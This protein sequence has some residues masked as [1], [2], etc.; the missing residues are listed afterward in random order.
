MKSP[1][2]KSERLY[3][4]LGRVARLLYAIENLDIIIKMCN[5][6][7][8]VDISGAIVH[9]SS[10]RLFERQNATV[11]FFLYVRQERPHYYRLTTINRIFIRE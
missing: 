8:I 11:F 1:R 9:N 2:Q 7:F 3:T 10:R 6:L 4:A 5:L